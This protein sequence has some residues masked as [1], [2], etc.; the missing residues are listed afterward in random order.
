MTGPETIL[1]QFTSTELVEVFIRGMG[2]AG[3]FVLIASGL[4]LIFGLMGVLNFAHGSLTTYGAFAGA[5]ILLSI[6]SADSTGIAAV[7][8]LVVTAVGVFAVLSVLGASIEFSLIRRLYERPP[9]DQILLTFGVALV[10]DEFLTI[11]LELWNI[12][13]FRPY[14]EPASYGPAF[15]AEGQNLVLGGVSVRWLYIFEFVVGALVVVAVWAFLNQTRYGLY[16]R[17][18]SEDDEMAEALGINVRRVFTLV[19]GVGIGLAG[20]SGLFLIWDPV[21]QLEITLGAQALLP[22]FIVVVV[23]G[24]GTFKGTVVASAVAG[25]FAQFGNALF[26][27]QAQIAG[28]N[29]G[30]FPQLPSMLI[31]ILLIVMLIVKPTGLYGEEEVGGH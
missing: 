7:A 11:V 10:L 1:L 28:V 30:D 13:P 2:T 14:S 15:L 31:F 17:A 18:G 21:Y 8:A 25:I 9:I 26:T 22:A 29:L 27:N 24:L 19:F 3:V 6:S 5:A 23:G 16:I 12:D 20:V 4:S